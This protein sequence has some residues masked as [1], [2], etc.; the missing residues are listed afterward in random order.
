MGNLGDDRQNN[1]L[2]QDK[3]TFEEKSFEENISWN[4]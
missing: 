3:I 1:L 2:F 4:A